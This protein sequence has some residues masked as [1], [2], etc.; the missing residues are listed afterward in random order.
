MDSKL[1]NREPSLHGTNLGPLHVNDSWVA[2]SVGGASSSGSRICSWS[3]NWHFGTYSLW[4]DVSLSL[5]AGGRA[6]SCL[7]LMC[8]AMLIPMESTFSEWMGGGGLRKKV[9]RGN[10]RQGNCRWYVK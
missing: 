3:M 2:W 4:W 6:C 1:T 9:G 7:N 8:Q 5:D 10:R